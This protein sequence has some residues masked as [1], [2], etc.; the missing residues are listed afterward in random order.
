MTIQKGVQNSFLQ[1][2]LPWKYVIYSK[3]QN[4]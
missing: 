4:K 1:I 3:C 2:Y